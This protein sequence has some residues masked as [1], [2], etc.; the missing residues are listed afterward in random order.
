MSNILL[1]SKQ[2]LNLKVAKALNSV[3]QVRSNKKIFEILKD[4]I[5]EIL[6]NAFKMMVYLIFHLKIIKK[7]GN[8]KI[9]A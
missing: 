9:I 4:K 5:L 8:K 3:R 6:P 1:T 7:N 2:S